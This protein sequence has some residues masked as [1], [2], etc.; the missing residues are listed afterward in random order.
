M[1]DGRVERLRR[2]LGVPLLRFLGVSAVDEADPAA[3]LS[4][5]VGAES[6]NAAGT[7][8]GGTIAT[9]LDVVAYLVLLAQLEDGEEATTHTFAA[10]Y[11]SAAGGGDRVEAHATVLRRSAHLAFVAAEL[12][13]GS[14]LLASALVTK[15][16]RRR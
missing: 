10:S 5:V 1:N 13:A 4:F 12:R 16:I 7:L 6:L 3:G 8:H 9:V 2:A 14:G 15:S 11:V